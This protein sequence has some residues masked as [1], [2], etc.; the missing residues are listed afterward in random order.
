MPGPYPNWEKAKE[1]LGKLFFWG[2][3]SAFGLMALNYWL[4]PEKEL[5]AD[6]YQTQRGQHQDIGG[7]FG[8]IAVEQPLAANN[9]LTDQPHG[10][11]R[12]RRVERREREDIEQG[13]TPFCFRQR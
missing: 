10:H 3:V 4:T 9:A 6:Q 5:L 1:Q 11:H 8:F 2:I 12:Q 13:A 7:Y